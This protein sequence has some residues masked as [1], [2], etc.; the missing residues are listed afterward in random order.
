MIL[1]SSAV[2]GGM[3]DDP[4]RPRERI[5]GYFQDITFK[6]K[7][8]EDLREARIATEWELK[9]NRR[10]LA[11]ISHEIQTPMHAIL[12]RIVAVT[13][14]L[15]VCYWM[16]FASLSHR[17]ELVLPKTLTMYAFTIIQD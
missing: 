17:N 13:G 7:I 12:S 11:H 1:R 10:F 16:G 6:M 2:S 15:L 3:I 4:I 9:N 5:V 14:C 8:I